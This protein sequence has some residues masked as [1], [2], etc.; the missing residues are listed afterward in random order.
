[1]VFFHS[2]LWRGNEVSSKLSV[3]IY[4]QEEAFGYLRYY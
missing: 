3:G 4:K 2:L 1:M